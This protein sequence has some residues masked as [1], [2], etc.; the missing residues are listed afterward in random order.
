MNN[1]LILIPTMARMLQMKRE[2]TSTLPVS[3]WPLV[4]L[5]AHSWISWTKEPETNELKSY[6]FG[7]YST[8][9]L[10][11]MLSYCLHSLP[12]VARQLKKKELYNQKMLKFPHIWPVSRWYQRGWGRSS[13]QDW[14]RWSRTT[15][16]HQELSHQLKSTSMDRSFNWRL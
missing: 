13:Y 4:R 9:F 12:S 2:T 6:H 11:L 7:V 8:Y 15:A 10:Q 16:S 1:T 3:V 5:S 14:Q